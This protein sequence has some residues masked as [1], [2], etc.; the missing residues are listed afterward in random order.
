MGC[1]L[2]RPFA[3]GAERIVRRTRLRLSLND[4]AIIQEFDRRLMLAMFPHE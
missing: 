4:A 1:W 3:H 2:A